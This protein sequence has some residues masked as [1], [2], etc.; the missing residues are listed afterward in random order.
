MLALRE[1]QHVLIQG[2]YAS[3]DTVRAV[4][5]VLPTGGGKTVCFS[6]IIHDHQGAS[7]VI[8]HRKEILDQ[9][10]RALGRMEVRH[11]IVAP[12]STLRS[13]RR[14][15]V[16]EFGRSWIDDTSMTGVV[17]VQTLTSKRA[18]ADTNLQRWLAQ[19]SLA[20]FDEGHHYVRKG[21]WG[22]AVRMFDESKLLF[23][24]AT[25]QRADGVGLGTPELGGEGFV[26]EMVE[27]P[28]TRWLIDNKFL[29]PYRYLA[30]DTD[31]DISGLAV[32]A[33]GDLNTKALRERE[34]K[35][36]L[37]GDV[38]KQYLQHGNG[39]RA[40]VFASNI[41]TAEELAVAFRLHGVPAAALSGETDPGQRD[42]DIAAFESGELQVLVNVDLFD[43]G[44]DVPAADVAILARVTMSLAKYLQMCG[45]VL[46]WL[47]GKVATIID[48]VRNWERHGLPDWPRIWS[49][50]SAEK[51]S[52]SCTPSDAPPLRNCLACTQ[53]FPK[54]LPRCPYCS[55][56]VE[57]AGRGSPEQVDGDL[58]ELDVDAMRALFDKMRRAEMSR[59]EFAQDIIA[60]NV[61]PVGRAAEMRRHESAKYRR[62]VLRH[63][64]GWWVGMQGA[65]PMP[66]VH[67][68]FYHR[69]GVDIGTA[70][71]LGA[72]ETDALI[73]TMQERF[74]YD[75]Q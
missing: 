58:A 14:R 17:S 65:R 67:R 8:A 43:E 73:S 47:E 26:E 20:A 13:I 29:A 7:A 33:T 74:H 54:Y 27:G 49:L 55:A 50:A 2:C 42:R 56:P 19:V 11:R 35:S 36:H 51:G 12:M 15:H 46:R 32:T 9:I 72:R 71:T 40:I 23:V 3:W 39:G 45:R 70:F 4:L 52:R 1:Y 28:T 44:F 25:P 41:A 30:P 21:Q 10:S 53:P 62:S 38:V 6:Q 64:V 57:Y 68:R 18:A 5:A 69:F 75:L 66:E 60:R 34:V 24:T 31:L 61:P 22:K 59:E 16:K 63:M 37:V 48:P